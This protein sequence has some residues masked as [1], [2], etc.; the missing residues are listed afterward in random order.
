MKRTA[1]IAYQAF[2][3][4]VLQRLNVVVLWDTDSITGSL[5]SI[6]PTE[7]SSSERQ[8][9]DRESGLRALFQT[10]CETCSHI[11]QYLPWSKH[12]YSEIAMQW[13]QKGQ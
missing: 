2:S 8:D 6:S 4:A 5:F 1:Q 7:S 9:L 13:W 10:L 3:R 12:S 11:D